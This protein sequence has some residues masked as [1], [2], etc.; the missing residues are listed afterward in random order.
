MHALLI[1]DNSMEEKY[2]FTKKGPKYKNKNRNTRATRNGYW[3]VID[4]SEI[5]LFPP[6]NVN[7]GM[8]MIKGVKKTLVYHFSN[9]VP[10]D[11]FMHEYSLVYNK[12]SCI[13]LFS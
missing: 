2:F 7:L 13:I 11:W 1:V 8:M 10:S 5:H 12:V 3:K 4:G 9:N 6:S